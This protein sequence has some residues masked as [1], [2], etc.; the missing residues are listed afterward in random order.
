MGISIAAFVCLIDSVLW[1]YAKSPRSRLNIMQVIFVVFFAI[2]I[3]ALARVRK[4]SDSE[5]QTSNESIWI[6]CLAIL[7]GVLV[8]TTMLTNYFINDDFGL[9]YM[10]RTPLPQLM[11]S[12]FRHGDG[13]FYRPL[14]FSS[15]A[16]D[17][18]VWGD[19]P[20]GYH[21]TNL[22][23]HIGSLAGLFVML[24]QLGIRRHTSAL[25]VGIFAAMPAIVEPVAWMS[26]RFDVMTTTLAVWTIA[27]YLWS[28]SRNNVIGFVIGDVL[29]ILAI[30]T[31]ETGFVIPLL[32]IA[33]DFI[34]FRRRPNWR[35][36]GLLATGGL[37]FLY[38][39]VA[40]G[41]IG[42]YHNG[43]GSAAADFTW[44]T[45]YGV[46]LRSP[47]QM[48]FGLN[49]MQPSG[50]L[51][52][53]LAAV[54]AAVTLLIATYAVLE[55]EQGRIIAL[56][57]FWIVIAMLPAHFL[58]LIGPGLTNSRILC[59]PT[60]G[61]AIVLGQLLGSI[62]NPRFQM[63]LFVLFVVVLNLGVLHNLAAWRWTSRLGRDTVQQ[64]VKAAPAPP[65]GAQFVVSD[66]PE[67]VRGVLFLEACLT[68]SLKLAYGRDDISAVRDLKSVAP[69]EA[70]APPP[71]IFLIW[72]GEPGELIRRQ[73]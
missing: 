49:W 8:W 17:H 32:L 13:T 59:L 19:L 14:S 47:S 18:A 15:F 39:I 12:L 41:G 36:G 40:I 44:G 72:K 66:M 56:A 58:S 50:F 29:Y 42:G 68:E 43:G 65:P 57:M 73:E 60:V 21:L 61:M 27:S 46:F 55:V 4:K 51:V 52:T 67:T 71:R 53:T 28:L 69:D 64:I 2:V 6:P 7:A 45:V 70:A 33:V 3:A 37:A 1:F 23:L 54:M 62:R 35:I 31:K 16:W 26:G 20:V 25:T 63:S 48:L 34:I 22:L 11:W 5:F 24:R 38:R 9:L 30:F 10:S